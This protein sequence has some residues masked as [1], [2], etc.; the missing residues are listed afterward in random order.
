MLISTASPRHR[1][2]LRYNKGTSMLCIGFSQYKRLTTGQTLPGIRVNVSQHALSATSTSLPSNFPYVLQQFLIVMVLQWFPA[3]V[4]L[5]QF[6]I[7]VLLQWFP[8]AVVLQQ[9]PIVVL[10]QWFPAAVVQQRFPAVVVWH[11]IQAAVVLQR[12]PAVVVQQRIQAGVILQRLPAALVLA[13]IVQ[14]FVALLVL[15]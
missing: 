3:A 5:Q 15:T 13:E 6:P 10:L 12:F 7:V 9:F 11:R 1:S 8:A 14:L 4:V 2:F